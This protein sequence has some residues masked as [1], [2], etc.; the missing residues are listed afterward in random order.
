[1]ETVHGNARLARHVAD[2]DDD[3]HHTGGGVTEIADLPTAETDTTL[4]LS[5]D[6]AGGV[7][8][9]S[10]PP[11]GIGEILIADTHSTPLVFGDLL[12]N[13]VQSDLLYADT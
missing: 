12:Q 7:E 6:G 8:W 10:P 5:P 11:S 9:T 13:D 2:I 3:G 1:M 4:V